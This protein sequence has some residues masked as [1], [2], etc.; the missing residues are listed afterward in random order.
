MA[1]KGGVPDYDGEPV[2]DRWPLDSELIEVAR[3]WS[4]DPDASLRMTA[5]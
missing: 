2:A 5:A 3:R 4:I 1:L